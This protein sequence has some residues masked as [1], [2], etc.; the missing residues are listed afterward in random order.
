MSLGL[1]V[2]ETSDKQSLEIWS[3]NVIYVYQLQLQS[4]Y[5]LDNE[6]IR[7]TYTLCRKRRLSK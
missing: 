5:H 7:S 1:L 2:I 4:S 6:L 3:V